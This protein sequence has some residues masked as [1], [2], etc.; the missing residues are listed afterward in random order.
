MDCIDSQITDIYCGLHA[1]RLS[2]QFINL[3]Q[4][5]CDLTMLLAL[6]MS[7]NQSD[8]VGHKNTRYKNNLSVLSKTKS[9]GKFELDREDR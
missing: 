4:A 9:K 7:H 8:I 5:C 2:D 3:G 6:K 1:S